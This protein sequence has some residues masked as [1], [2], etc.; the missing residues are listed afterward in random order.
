MGKIDRGE[1]AEQIK[2]AGT[3]TGV[4]EYHVRQLPSTPG[5]A[6]VERGLEQV[7]KGLTEIKREAEID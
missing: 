1:A 7:R 6:T 5:R 4:V 2:E 3:Y